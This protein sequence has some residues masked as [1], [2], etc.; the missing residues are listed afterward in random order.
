MSNKLVFCFICV[1]TIVLVGYVNTI[2][3]VGYVSISPSTH[4]ALTVI[5]LLLQMVLPRQQMTSKSGTLTENSRQ[6]STLSIQSND[7]VMT[8]E[9]KDFCDRFHL[10][11]EERPVPHSTRKELSLCDL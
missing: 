2:V 9:D 3:L 8:A 7:S 4:F 11:D 10:P 5:L 6:S 1:S